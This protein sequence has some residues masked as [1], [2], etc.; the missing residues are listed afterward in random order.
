ATRWWD[1]DIGDPEIVVWGSPIELGAQ[2]WT[3]SIRDFLL[4]ST[5]LPAF[6]MSEANLAAFVAKIQTRRP[7]MLFGYPSALAH[8]ARHAE[9]R[10]QLLK[11][12]GVR[13]AFVTS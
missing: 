13:V 4:R 12:V 5:L 9:S 6:E 7:V 10:G 3:R 2:D 11:D 1:V 8:I